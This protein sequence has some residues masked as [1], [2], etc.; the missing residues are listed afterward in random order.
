MLVLRESEIKGFFFL[1]IKGK[2]IPQMKKHSIVCEPLFLQEGADDKT[3]KYIIYICDMEIKSLVL[4]AKLRAE[5][6]CRQPQ[7]VP[8]DLLHLLHAAML[9]RS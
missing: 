3:I 7:V 9:G 2:N 8:P 6:N 5:L 1:K 4:E